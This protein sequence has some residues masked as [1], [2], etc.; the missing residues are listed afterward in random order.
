MAVPV[1]KTVV[2]QVELEFSFYVLLCMAI[3]LLHH[4]FDDDDVRPFLR[5]YFDGCTPH[6]GGNS[7]GPVKASVL[8]LG[9][10]AV[11][12]HRKDEED[13]DGPFKELS[14]LW[15][16]ED[17]PSDSLQKSKTGAA[18]AGPHQPA[19]QPP[20]PG[21]EGQSD[22]SSS[23]PTQ[24]TPRSPEKHHPLNDVF[25][26]LLSW[27]SAYRTLLRPKKFN[28]TA[29]S[30][31]QPPSNND[32]AFCFDSLEDPSHIIDL[33]SNPLLDPQSDAGSESGTQSEGL[34]ASP[35]RRRMTPLA[36]TRRPA[37]RYG[38]K[39]KSSVDVRISWRS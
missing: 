3:R 33:K 30:V 12:P 31:V 22:A 11:Q 19:A 15:P 26:M 29:R 8:L 4:K 32:D 38:R 20:L 39:R 17:A 2:I 27:F 10:I 16:D 35:R 34:D 6:S 18:E 23:A 7:C 25:E 1:R 14:F 28:P 37:P 24:P 21:S 13:G 36:P 9:C 5:D